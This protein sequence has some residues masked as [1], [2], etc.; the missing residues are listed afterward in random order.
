VLA[1]RRETE[2]PLLPGG[3]PR[4]NIRRCVTEL[5]SGLAV[6]HGW[7]PSAAGWGSVPLLLVKPV[8]FHGAGRPE[9]FLLVV[10]AAYLRILGTWVIMA[11]SLRPK[12]KVV[13]GLGFC[14]KTLVGCHLCESATSPLATVGPSTTQTCLSLPS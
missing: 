11:Y 14:P 8:F 6:I 5:P 7:L 12:T 9:N 13:L 4:Y 3:R 10:S 2:R 1:I